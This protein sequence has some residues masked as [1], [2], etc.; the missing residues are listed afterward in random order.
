MGVS[1]K[2]DIS[3]VSPVYGCVDAL[4]E[5]ATRVAQTCDAAGLTWE[6]ILVDDRGPGDPWSIIVDLAKHDP[7]IRGVRLARNSGQHLAIWAGL[8]R[9]RGAWV[10]VVDCDL[11]DDPAALAELHEMALKGDADAVVVDRGRWSDNAMRRMASRAFY[12]IV[13]VLA[14]VQLKNIGNFGIYSRRLVDALLQYREQQ[15]FLPLMVNLTGYR[16]VTLVIDRGSRFSG[17]SSYSYTKLIRMAVNLVVQF[18]DRP[19]KLSVLLGLV[20]STGSALVAV[21]LLVL[22]ALG[23]FE[24]EG[25]TSIMLSIWFLF[26]VVLAVLGI[27][28]FY[29]GRVLA[30]TQN[31]PRFIVESTT[32][33]SVLEVSSR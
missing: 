31:R 1:E 2:I 24:V 19:L 29:L 10:G 32:E 4:R 13:T 6:L 18:S 16:A 3:V 26:G 30:E 11:Q 22:W 9:S 15:V 12:R 21:A 25:W 20:L 5:L 17:D 14:G 33:G 23:L 8:E 7:R 27:H 28:G